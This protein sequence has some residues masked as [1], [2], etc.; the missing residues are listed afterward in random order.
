MLLSFSLVLALHP[1]TSHAPQ[2]R[3]ANGIHL[4][5]LAHAHA[6]SKFESK[7]TGVEWVGADDLVRLA[8]RRVRRS[9]ARC[10]VLSRR[11]PHRFA[12][13]HCSNVH[14]DRALSLSR[15]ARTL[16]PHPHPAP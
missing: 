13:P 5:H 9:A 14:L 12:A 7:V 8:A 2:R 4:P 16:T 3:H 10:V 1:F 6:Q 15:T 11:A